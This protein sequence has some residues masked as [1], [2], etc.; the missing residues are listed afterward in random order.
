M[1]AQSRNS[2]PNKRVI[3]KVHRNLNSPKFAQSTYSANVER[4][5][6]VNSQ[7]ISVRAT[8]SDGKVRRQLLM[9]LTT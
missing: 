8:D 2:S 4:N 9:I 7:V 6:T 1:G 3:V 5:M